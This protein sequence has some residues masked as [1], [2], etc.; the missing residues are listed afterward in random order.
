MP[1]EVPS[2]W[3][4]C[5]VEDVFDLNPKNNLDDE[6]IAGFIPM[7][8]VSAG[9]G[10]SHTFEERKW[11]EVKKGYC[12]FRNG[13][14]GIA[15]I[16]PCFENR[17]STIF[18]D[19]PNDVGAGTTELVILRGHCVCT[20]FYLYLFQSSWYIDEGTK[21]FKGNVG[22]QRVKKDIFTILQIPLPPLAE[23]KRIV[24]ELRQWL[25]IAEC[26]EVKNTELQET[27]LKTKN[28]VLDLAIHG[29][30]VPQDLSDE[31][32]SELLK[33]VAPN[34][35]AC[36]TSHYENIP[37]SWCVIK[38]GEV[39]YHTTGKALKKS[40]TVGELHDYLTTSNVYWNSFDFTEVRSMYFSNEELEKCT[41][42]KGDLLVCNG[43]DVGRAAIWNYD[44][45][46]CIQNH[47]SRLRPKYNNVVDNLF[48][49]Y[50]FSYLKQK[51]KL[52]G[53]G[54]A[55]TSLSATDIL[56][57]PIPL[58]PIQEQK[59]IVNRLSEIF[60]YIDEISVEL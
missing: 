20:E 29:K 32:A 27:I 28:K 35:I 44:Y 25:A 49:C 14:I 24:A 13:D 41:V 53:K 37:I 36:D 10:Y 21:Y 54:V 39:Y 26:L 38:L 11:G 52:N 5:K 16:S 59:R 1:F 23:Q 3:E 7:E 30:L 9:F 42:Q 31:P 55:I 47:I 40:N 46:I 60:T 51:G 8:L 6:T 50:I 18:Y 43:G 17:K 12:H 45:T 2:S 58:P 33:R 48:Y 22:Q 34:A 15:K 57:I 19:L 56:S 4:W